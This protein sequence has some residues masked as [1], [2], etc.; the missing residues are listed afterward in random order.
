MECPCKP[1]FV[2][3]TK[4]TY[5]T[6]LKSD[7]HRMFQLQKDLETAQ[8]RIAQLENDLIQKN[9]VERSLITSI[10]SYELWIRNL[11]QTKS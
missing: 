9:C 1:D 2:F 10:N 7:M 4:T 5:S 6:H 3:R 11:G 8:N